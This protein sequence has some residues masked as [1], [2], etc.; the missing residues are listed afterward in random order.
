MILR[1]DSLA[2]GRYELSID[3]K[4]IASF[5]CEELQHGVNLALYKTPML[6]QSREIDGN[7]DRR[8]TLDLARF[9]LSAEIKQ[10]ATSGVAEEKLREAGDEL[11]A[12]TR[13]D[14]DPKPHHVELR[15][16]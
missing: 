3:S 5:S 2:P 16:Q 13:K 8:A 14:L 10:S 7:E 6:D 15:R 1:V 11:E 4:A 9:V 12:G